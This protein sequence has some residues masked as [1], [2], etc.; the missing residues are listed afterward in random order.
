MPQK[1]KPPAARRRKAPAKPKRAQS[2]LEFLKSVYSEPIPEEADAATRAR[3]IANKLAAAKAAAAYEMQQ[4][5]GEAE[6]EL[7]ALLREIE[8]T[9]GASDAEPDDDER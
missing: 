8:A 1:P 2:P 7:A 9:A 4:R 6:G 3:I 5:D